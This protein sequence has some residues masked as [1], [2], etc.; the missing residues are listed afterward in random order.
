M[1]ASIQKT[2]YLDTII[3]KGVL[4]LLIFTPLAIGTV[5]PWSISIMEMA[6]FIVF[7]AWLLK[8]GAG[9]DWETSG[10]GSRE[11]GVGSKALSILFAGFVFLIILQILPMP[12]ALLS[13][14][15]PGTGGLYAQFSLPGDD[16][17]RTLS[18]YPGATTIELYK[19]LAYAAVFIVI[20]NHYRTREQVSSIIHAIVVMGCFLAIFAVVQKMTWNGNLFWFYPIKEGLRPMGPYINRNHFAG[21]MEMAVPLALG[22]L[23]YRA[24]SLNIPRGLPFVRRVGTMVAAEAFPAVAFLSLAFFIMSAALFASLSRGGMLGFASGLA[25][26]VLMVRA[27]RSLRKR[28]A[29]VAL[30]GFAVFVVVVLAGWGRIEDR[31]AELGNE[32]KIKRIEIWSDSMGI[33]RDFPLLGTGMGTFGDAYLRYQSTSPQLLF[34]HAHNDYI[35]FLTDMG[36]A[37]AALMAGMIGLFWRTLVLAWGERHSRFVTSTVA[38]GLAAFAALAVHS[39]TDFNLHIPANALLLTI[40]AAMSYATVFNVRGGRI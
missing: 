13:A 32:A 16:R 29:V 22:M 24:S 3:E 2:T 9:S 17:W 35:E 34:D 12:P 28:M 21:Y 14:L 8:A 26:F 27:R 30:V 23:L 10:V 1:V 38:G 40:I 6:A 18:I 19:I 7:G 39:I 15:S 31:F 36:L 25:S 33:V 5:Q 4:F 37:G 11:L 20:I